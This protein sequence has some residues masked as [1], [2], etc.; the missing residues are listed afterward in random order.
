MNCLLAVSQD[1][2]AGAAS[3][4]EASGSIRPVCGGRV[5]G[6][7]GCGAEG[8]GVHTGRERIGEAEAPGWRG[9]CDGERGLKLREQ[10]GEGRVGEGRG[11]KKTHEAIRVKGAGVNLPLD[12]DLWPVSCVYL[13]VKRSGFGI[14]QERERRSGSSISAHALFR[15]LTDPCSAPSAETRGHAPGRVR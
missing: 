1:F 7:G 3:T 5:G 4:S 10:G 9:T 15:T 12:V 2:P 13:R 8:T 14:Y 6:W 11:I